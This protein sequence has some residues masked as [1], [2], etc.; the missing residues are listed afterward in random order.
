MDCYQSFVRKLHC[1]IW[2]ILSVDCNN[3]LTRYSFHSILSLNTYI[4]IV[5]I[6]N[7]QQKWNLSIHLGLILAK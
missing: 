2:N 6:E 3:W 4:F 5:Q 7:H 1:Q